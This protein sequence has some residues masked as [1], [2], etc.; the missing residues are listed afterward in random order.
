MA[1]EVITNTGYDMKVFF[2]KIFNFFFFFV[3]LQNNNSIKKKA[4]IWSLGITMIE[5]AHGAPPYAHMHPIKVL[6]TIAKAPPPQLVGPFSPEFRDI[7]QQCLRKN[8]DEV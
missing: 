4:D 1:P 6:Y 2:K 7:V 5:M 8:P 3:K